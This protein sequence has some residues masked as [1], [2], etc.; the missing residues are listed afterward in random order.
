M[1]VFLTKVALIFI[2]VLGVIVF[3][4]IVL[5]I[6]GEFTPIKDVITK[7][8]EGHML[9]GLAYSDQSLLYK[10]VA[11][12]VRKPHVLALGN[13]KILT[14]RKEFFKDS[15]SFYNAGGTTPNISY[16]RRFLETTGVR[17]TTLIIT[18]EPLHFDPLLKVETK[19]KTFTFKNTTEPVRILSILSRSWLKVYNDY[20]NNKFTLD[21]LKNRDVLLE[22]GVVAVTVKGG[23]RSD[24]SYQYGQHYK[25]LLIKS[26][27]INKAVTFITTLYRPETKENFSSQALRELDALLQYCKERNI[28][29]IGYIPPMPTVIEEAYISKSHYDFIFKTYE[30]TRPVFKKYNFAI[31]DYHSLHSLASSDDET[32]DEYHTGEK[33]MVRMMLDIAKKDTYFNTLVSKEVLEAMLQQTKGQDAVIVK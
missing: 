21:Q 1:K 19:E 16:F 31:Y 12:E 30:K 4:F 10:V 33:V 13:S 32:L 11:T 14:M 29:V 18:V 17:P 27:K 28:K 3:P 2:P 22:T 15:V 20:H 26:E 7:Q 8:T 24:G 25:D 9:Y 23:L 5:F 6:S